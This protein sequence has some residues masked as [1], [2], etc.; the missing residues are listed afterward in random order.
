MIKD[1]LVSIYITNHNY[2]K[3]IEK[4]IK[5][6]VNQNYK[7]IEI[8]IVDDCSNDDSKKIFNKFLNI[9]NVKLIF[10][11]KKIG[12]VKSA[13]KAIKRSKGKYFIRLDADDVFKKSA[14]EQLVEIVKKNKNISMLFSNFH[15]FFEKTKKKKEF[16]YMNKKKYSLTDFSAHGACSLI[17]R[18]SF[19]KIG[20]YSELFDRQ[21]GF[22]IWT[23]FLIKNYNIAHLNKSLFYYRI[24]DKNL[25]KNYVKILKVRKKII[26]YFLIKNLK[27]K[28]LIQVKKK[29]EKELISLK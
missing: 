13:N 16:R 28:E 26:S 19:E 12:L 24:H 18:S 20:G 21:D 22:Y 6:A 8:I 9:K 29:T 23:A 17:K 5:S 15:F 2:G 11:S 1:P 4:S 27:N 10:N 3:Y 7:N 25:S 14:I